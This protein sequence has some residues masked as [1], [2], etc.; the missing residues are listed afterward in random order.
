M[1]LSNR[2]QTTLQS[3]CKQEVEGKANEFSSNNMKV[4]NVMQK[5][6]IRLVWSGIAFFLFAATVL[7]LSSQP[8]KERMLVGKKKFATPLEWFEDE[9][10]LN[11]V[12]ES[13]KNLLDDDWLDMNLHRLSHWEFPHKE[14]ESFVSKHVH[15]E[16][17]QSVL[18]KTPC[19]MLEIGG[20]VG[21][22]SRS[23]L[24][25]YDSLSEFTSI[26][27][28]AKATEISRIVNK[29][30][31]RFR[32]ISA[33]MEDSKGMRATIA[34]AAPDIS[35][36]DGRCPGSYDIAIM[37]GVLCYVG[38]EDLVRITLENAFTELRVDGLL[39][40]SMLPKTRESMRSC[41][42]AI[43]LPMIE[44]ISKTL[45]YEI[46]TT[47]DMSKWGTGNQADRYLVVLR[48]TGKIGE[49]SCD[50]TE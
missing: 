49:S 39:I 25:S 28:S 33:S 15:Y 21:A 22:F 46:I 10:T 16:D 13:N 11:K 31:A 19:R 42:T 45:Q 44:R 29:K 32:A 34:A 24:R 17:V 2:R 26:E 5:R 9:K 6:H 50:H 43:P 47:D 14:W 40:I 7:L 37:S 35:S 12:G 36:W 1:K 18:K 27:K 8:Q 23:L 4:M 38:T 30:D 48:K 41:E 20:G 3:R